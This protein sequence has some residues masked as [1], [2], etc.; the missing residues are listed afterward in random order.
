MKDD[1][2]QEIEVLVVGISAND[3][4]DKETNKRICGYKVGYLV[5]TN[6]NMASGYEYSQK[7][8][9][10]ED[11]S[12]KDKQLSRQ[13]PFKTKM[14]YQYVSLNELPKILDIII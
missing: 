14:K 3:F 4:T 5:P 7:W 13:F 2:I 9:N 12:D 11:L 8:L 6:K 1:S 10:R